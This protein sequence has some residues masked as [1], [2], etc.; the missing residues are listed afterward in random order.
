MFLIGDMFEAFV[1]MVIS[2]SA[3]FAREYVFKHSPSLCALLIQCDRCL[4]PLPVW[5]FMA[6]FLG[7]AS[8][9]SSLHLVA[10]CQ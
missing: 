8:H 1:E 3:V 5:G 6:Q 4:S 2:T 9:V 10:G 7:V